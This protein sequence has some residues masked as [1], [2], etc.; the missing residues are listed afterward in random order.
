MDASGESAT[1]AWTPQ[2]AGLY[3]VDLHVNARSPDGIPVERIAFLTV[4]A[5]PGTEASRKES[6]SMQGRL[7]L[8]ALAAGGVGLSGFC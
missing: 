5:Q 1:G 8:T 3:G 4:E 7:A 2:E 6:M